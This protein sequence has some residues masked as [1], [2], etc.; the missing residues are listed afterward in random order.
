MTPEFSRH[1]HADF[2]VNHRYRKAEK[3]VRILSAERHLNGLVFL[4]IGAGS[5][6]ISAYLSEIAGSDGSVSAV[7]VVDEC[8]V[9]EGYDFTRV[10]GVK[11]PFEDQAFDVVISNHVIEHVGGE[12]EQLTHLTEIARVLRP[13]GIGYLAVPNRWAL[14]EPHFQLWFLSWLPLSLGNYYVRTTNR[15]TH[16]DCKPLG[17]LDIRSMI[18]NSGMRYQHRSPAAVRLVGK[19]EGRP[20][21]QRLA[22]MLPSS[23]LNVLTPFYPTMIFLIL[24]S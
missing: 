3:I 15:G 13:T 18:R 8:V 21:I 17:P 24:P 22:N 12:P 6:V 19:I 10:E 2:D 23:F 20:I 9:R 16:Y 7:D 5:G 4:E 1:S 14:V 11:L